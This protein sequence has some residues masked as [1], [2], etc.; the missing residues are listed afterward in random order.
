MGYKGVYLTWTCF[1]DANYEI[2]MAFMRCIVCCCFF[3]TSNKGPVG[4]LS[5]LLVVDGDLAS[6]FLK[7][8][9][10]GLKGVGAKK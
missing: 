2:L 3:F 5:F 10:F 1:P 9:F 4:K 7:G 8:L 6:I